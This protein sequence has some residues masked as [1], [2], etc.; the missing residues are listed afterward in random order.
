[1]TKKKEATGVAEFNPQFPNAS[2]DLEQFD[3][4]KTGELT[5]QSFKDYLALLEELCPER[6]ITRHT[7]TMFDFEWHL[8][9]PVFNELYPGIPNSP[10]Y[11]DGIVLKTDPKKMTSV[12]S[13]TRIS[14]H[15]A[16]TLN[17]QIENEHSRNGHGRYL[18]LIIPKSES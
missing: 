13:K 1:M 15:H 6:G 18:L 3:Y 4:D 7:N 11:L 5:G 2:L 8:A 16:R 17:A 9:K 14:I 10:K 12:V